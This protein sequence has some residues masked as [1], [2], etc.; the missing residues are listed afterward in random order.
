MLQWI[1]L[2]AQMFIDDERGQD[3]AEFAMVSVFIIVVLIAGM[4]VMDSNYMDMWYKLRH[5][6]LSVAN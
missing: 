2:W 3:V 5:I 4:G 1:T 6:L